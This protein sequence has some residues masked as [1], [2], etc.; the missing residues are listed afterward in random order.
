MVAMLIM[1]SMSGFEKEKFMLVKT[2]GVLTI[3]SLAGFVLNRAITLL[4]T[5]Y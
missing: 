4:D 2:V 1:K 5:D 3:L